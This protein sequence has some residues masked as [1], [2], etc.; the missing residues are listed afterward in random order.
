MRCALYPG[1]RL[2][3]LRRRLRHLVCGHDRGHRVVRRA[4]ARGRRAH[5]RARRGQ[6]T[7]RHPDRA[8]DRQA[9]D[10]HRPLTGDARACPRAVAGPAGGAARGRH[11][12]LRARAA[13]RP[14]HLSVSLAAPS[15]DLAGQA[16]R[17]RAGRDGATSGRT[18]RLERVRVQPADR[19]VDPRSPD[20][21]RGRP[22]GDQSL[23]PVGEPAR[24]DARRGRGDA[25]S[26][27]GLVGR[28][29]R[30]GRLDRRCGARGRGSVRRFAREPF[31]DDSLELVWVARKPL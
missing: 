4:R 24:A 20:R 8:G 31:D 10:R 26:P 30:V 14:R 11:A 28:Q 7:R 15:A 12:G 13:G 5:R 29:S 16:P 1:E 25:R 3:P 18:V 9:R 23:H 19:R 17:V 21:A 2:R 27:A 6:R 22:V